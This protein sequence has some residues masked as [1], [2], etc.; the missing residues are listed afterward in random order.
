MAKAASTDLQLE[1]QVLVLELHAVALISHSFHPTSEFF[2]LGHCFTVSVAFNFV[3]DAAA[4]G[5]PGTRCTL[6]KTHT[7]HR[8]D[9]VLYWCLRKGGKNMLLPIFLSEVN[10][11]QPPLPPSLPPSLRLSLSLPFP[12]THLSVWLNCA[13]MSPCRVALVPTPAPQ[14]SS[15]AAD[16]ARRLQTVT[17]CSPW[18]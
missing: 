12:P 6:M 13:Y 2:F 10:G 4:Q 18:K 11:Q 3:G 1:W 14:S 9:W 15:H 17:L 8:E 7:L 16:G 5:Q